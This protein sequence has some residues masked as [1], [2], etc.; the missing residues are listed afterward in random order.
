MTKK[1][2]LLM[3]FISFLL[4][5]CSKPISSSVPPN[6]NI[7]YRELDTVVDKHYFEYDFDYNGVR[8]M[9]ISANFKRD[10]GD[11]MESASAL[12]QIPNGFVQNFD[13]MDTSLICDNENYPYVNFKK[14]GDSIYF[15]PSKWVAN[16]SHGGALNIF[17]YEKFAP[18][19]IDKKCGSYNVGDVYIPIRFYARFSYGEGWYNGWV[20]LHTTDK[21]L[22]IKSVAWYKSPETPIKA[23]EK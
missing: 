18:M 4:L 21:K 13:V 5:A 14:L 9:I 15:K 6:P 10:N 12:I 16:K 20:L 7:E 1:M 19:N 17:Y 23:G 2:T 3:N 8:E 11:G 22:L